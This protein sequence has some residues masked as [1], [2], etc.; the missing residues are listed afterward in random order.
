M[1]IYNMCL[2]L[3]QV[4]VCNLATKLNLASVWGVAFHEKI[5]VTC[6]LIVSKCNCHFCLCSENSVAEPEA[7]PG[8]PDEAP[9]AEDSAA[10]LPSGRRNPPGGKSSLILGWIPANWPLPYIHSSLN[11][12][13]FFF[14]LCFFFLT[15]NPKPICLYRRNPIWCPTGTSLLHIPKC[16]VLIPLFWKLFLYC[17]YCL[18]VLTEALYVFLITWFKV[19]PLPL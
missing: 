4:E 2:V 7:A 10:G 15:R 1:Q 11:F 5:I 14:Q 3:P 16:I 6:V 19:L 13:F 17:F 8:Q 18:F 9:P 12:F